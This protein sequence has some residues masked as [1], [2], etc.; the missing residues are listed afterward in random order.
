MAATDLNDKALVKECLTALQAQFPKSGR[1]RRLR[2]MSSLELNERYEEALTEYNNMIAADESN[3]LLY[4]RKISI[5]IAAKQTSEAIKSLVDYL[6]KFLNDHEAWIQLANLYIR[7]QE[8]VRAAFC[9]EELILTSPHNHLYHEKYAEVQ[10]TIGTADS[11]ELARA[12]FAQAARLKPSSVRALYG[13][14]L[15]SN[16]LAALPKTTV[17]KKK[18]CQKLSAWAADALSKIYQ[19]NS[20]ADEKHLEGLESALASLQVAN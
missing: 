19:E 12:Y 18:E 7:E 14:L 6:K 16:A 2:M 1:V 11:L 9:L 13:L 20:G 8:Y 4:K 15:S 3:P 10:Y 17:P 5:L